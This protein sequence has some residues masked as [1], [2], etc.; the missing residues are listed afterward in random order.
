LSNTEHTESIV[1]KLK[2]VDAILGASENIRTAKSAWKSGERLG[3]IQDS[4]AI[5]ASDIQAISDRIDS[6]D[7]IL[8]TDADAIVETGNKL[9]LLASIQERLFANSSESDSLKDRIGALSSAVKMD[10]DELMADAV[11]LERIGILLDACMACDDS[12]SV[13][14]KDSSAVKSAIEKSGRDVVKLLKSASI[15][16]LSGGKLFDECKQ[17]IGEAT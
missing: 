12:L 4:L 10:V 5:G 13:L 3:R 16:P 6:L 1:I 9:T 8:N 11:K 15:C 14:K 17:L 7:S 2:S